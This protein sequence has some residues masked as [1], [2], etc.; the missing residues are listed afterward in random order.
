MGTP[1]LGTRTKGKTNVGES[2][3]LLLLSVPLRLRAEV[4]GR[5]CHGWIQAVGKDRLG[6]RGWDVALY[7][8]EQWECTDSA[9]GWI[10]S[11][12]RA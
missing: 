2:L 7:V 8:G 6:R 3:W 5:G 4:T 11:Q 12:S 1:I 9:L 10:V